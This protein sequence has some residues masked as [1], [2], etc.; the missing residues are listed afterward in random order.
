MHGV[1]IG[2]Q[3]MLSALVLFGPAELKT[4]VI[5][6]L[7][8]C[9]LVFF[10]P[11]RDV[12]IYALGC[13]FTAFLIAVFAWFLRR[14][15]SSADI[16][17]REYLI[18]HAAA[19]LLALAVLTAAQ[20]GWL[21]ALRWMFVFE[22]IPVPAFPLVILVLP[23][24]ASLAL[25][26]EA[27]ARKLPAA[28]RSLV[29][30]L[31][32]PDQ[33]CELP[34]NFS[35][36]RALDL[37]VPVALFAVIYIP[38]ASRLAGRIFLQEEFHHWD[39]FAMGP[40]LAFHHGKALGTDSFAQYGVGWPLLFN[41]LS[42][43]IPIT[44]GSFIQLG[45]LYASA[46]FIGIYAL[47]RL[48]LTRVAWAAVGVFF[49]LSLQLFHGIDATDVMWRWPSSTVMRSA[50]DVWFFIA[51]WFHLRSG[52]GAWVLGAGALV[53]LAVLFETDTGIYLAL[54]F[55][56]YWIFSLGLANIRLIQG[57]A[58]FAVGGIVLLGGLAIASHGTLTRG[59]FWSGWTESLR[60]Y[61]AGV[62]LLPIATVPDSTLLFFAFIIALYFSEMGSALVA[63]LR[64]ESSPA[65]VLRGC[66]ASYGLLVM[67]LFVGRSHP[68]NIFH[69]LV[70]FGIVATVLVSQMHGRLATYAGQ[71]ER[72][73]REF[74]SPMTNLA[75]WSA[76]AAVVLWLLINPAF[77]NYPGLLQSMS[78][79]AVPT[80]LCL[81]HDQHDV[82]DLPPAASNYVAAFDATMRAIRERAT[83]GQSLAVLDDTDTIF[84]LAAGVKP[85]WRYSPGFAAITRRTELD[86][87]ESVLVNQ[88]PH[89]VFIRANDF[90]ARAFN[91]EDVWREVHSIVERRYTLD[92]NTG[93]FQIWRRNEK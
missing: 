53:G 74:C 72:A 45:T 69:V 40:A 14:R 44:Y 9:G 64:R 58:A 17:V 63:L 13:T 93:I 39:F 10:H 37:V 51:L 52:K 92:S 41:A 4:E 79:G 34:Q 60:S 47:L 87:L 24:I 8:R 12:P 38:G 20:I 65:T 66:I 11:E 5:Q 88:S 49:A 61:G 91:T 84:D 67:I 70:P 78:D 62:S 23:T 26:L 48:M 85:W 73:T 43:F 54:M 1:L 16:N 57:L 7:T 6:Q 75:P 80:G 25:M 33:V 27:V 19:Q 15:F 90:H 32:A 77:R 21:F 50:M 30:W 2:L 36:H 59:E 29:R 86:A 56:A 35:F 46:Y 83:G 42:G 31:N 18:D 55:A 71:R 28:P 89:F 82:C 22:K 76:F 68:S 81:L 3:V